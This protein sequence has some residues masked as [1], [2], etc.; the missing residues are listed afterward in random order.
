MRQDRRGSKNLR[1]RLIFG[2]D[3]GVDLEL[4]IWD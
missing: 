2:T 1:Q 4:M 3:H